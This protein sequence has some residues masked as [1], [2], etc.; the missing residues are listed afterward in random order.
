M[1]SV[2]KPKPMNRFWLAIL[3]LVLFGS[4]VLGIVGRVPQAKNVWDIAIFF[5]G[6]WSRRAFIRTW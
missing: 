1:K 4:A 3:V 5:A 6:S 2:L